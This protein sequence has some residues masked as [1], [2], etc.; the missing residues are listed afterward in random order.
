MHS[1]PFF[2]GGKRWAKA[3]AVI[4]ALAGLSGPAWAVDVTDLQH[5]TALYGLKFH[6]ADNSGA[7][8]DSNIDVTLKGSAP[9]YATKTIRIN[10]YI[11]GNAFERNSTDQ[12]PL[13]LDDQPY[14]Y[15]TQVT[16]KSDGA[17]AGSDWDFDWLQITYKNGKTNTF[18]FDPNH[19]IGEN[20]SVTRNSSEDTSGWAWGWYKVAIKTSDEA[21]GGTDSNISLTLKGTKGATQRTRL[22]GLLSGNAFERGDTD[23]V[24]LWS[25]S[26]AGQITEVKLENDGNYA[27]SDWHVATVEVTDK[28][29]KANTFTYNRWVNSDTPID[30]LSSFQPLEAKPEGTQDFQFV[31]FKFKN[32]LTNPGDVAWSETLEYVV[33]DSIEMSTE[34]GYSV[35]LSANAGWSA[36]DGGGAEASVGLTYDRFK[37]DNQAKVKGVETT[38]S[39]TVERTVPANSFMV[40]KCT[41]TVPYDMY[42]V[43]ADGSTDVRMRVLKGQPRCAESVEVYGGAGEKVMFFTTW[44]AAKDAFGAQWSDVSR[45]LQAAGITLAGVTGANGKANVE[46]KNHT[47]DRV[48]VAFMPAP[49]LLLHLDTLAPGASQTWGPIQ[50]TMPILFL[51]GAVSGGTYGAP[52]SGG[53]EIGSYV[54]GSEPK[55][56]YVIQ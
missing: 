33:S 45:Q 42:K 43:S 32:N 28:T 16:V 49:G 21:Q 52:V 9:L 46:F 2:G 25:D 4:L 17:Y 54:V 51:V 15:I 31:T 14:G 13:C 27:G 8:T 34:T 30:E 11:A 36:G 37:N 44:H 10:P 39:E 47:S 19:S 41:W 48:E 26:D 18:Q 38:G 35:G 50:E 56:L 3:G 12:V 7:G 20:E 53:T 55:Q 1:N 22:N 29:G 6:T 23:T 5:C 40:A 24:V